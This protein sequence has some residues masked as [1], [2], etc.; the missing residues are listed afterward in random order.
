MK[1]N[2]KVRAALVA[3]GMR[4]WQLADLLQMSDNRLSVFFRYEWDEDLQ[5]KIVSVIEG[6]NFEIM[7]IRRRLIAQR[8]EKLQ[9]RR[10]KIHDDEYY[11]GKYADMII[12]QV[13]YLERNREDEKLGRA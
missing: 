2:L 7:E 10:E 12:Q 5:D 3:N 6:E 4:H 1:T 9:I 11:A 8:P 13:D